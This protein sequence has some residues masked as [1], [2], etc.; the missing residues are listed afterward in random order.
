MAFIKIIKYA[1]MRYLLLIVMIFVLSF[2]ANAQTVWGI[3]LGNKDQYEQWNEGISPDSSVYKQYEGIE[4]WGKAIYGNDSLQM[5]IK[6]P[7]KEQFDQAFILLVNE[8]G[9]PSIFGDR[10]LKLE[11]EKEEAKGD[12]TKQ[13]EQGEVDERSIEAII[14]DGDLLMDRRWILVDYELE[15]IWNKNGISFLCRYLN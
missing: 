14:Q 11:R 5:R 13:E 2:K 10:N 8:Y 3:E 7:S 15:L 6:Y 9:E 1:F 4:F 12:Y